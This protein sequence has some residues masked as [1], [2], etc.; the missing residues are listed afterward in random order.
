LSLP[1]LGLEMNPRKGPKEQRSD[2][3]DGKEQDVIEGFRDE[4]HKLEG[5]KRRLKEETRRQ[6]S[7]LYD[8]IE[9]FLICLFRLWSESDA[10]DGKG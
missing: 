2:K 7:D 4:A 9:S 8:R 6:D 10:R 3:R 1:T 5:K